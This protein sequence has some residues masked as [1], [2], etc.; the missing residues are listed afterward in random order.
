MNAI[1]ALSQLSYIPVAESFLPEWPM[2]VKKKM[3]IL[4]PERPSANRHRKAPRIMPEK[5]LSLAMAL[6]PRGKRYHIS[7]Q[8]TS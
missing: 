6:H 7:I 2:I 5:R 1:Q 3:D 8:P 4:S